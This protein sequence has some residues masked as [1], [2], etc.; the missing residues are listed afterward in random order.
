MKTFRTA[1]NAIERVSVYDSDGN[2]YRVVPVDAKEY[3]ATGR[4]FAE[5]PVQVAE[6]PKRGQKT[7]EKEAE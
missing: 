2:E 7:S 4:Y 5:K 1:P 3:I 6:K